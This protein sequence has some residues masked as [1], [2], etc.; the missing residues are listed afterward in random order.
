MF[1][2]IIYLL[3]IY[4]VPSTLL[5]LVGKEINQWWGVKT[6]PGLSAVMTIGHL[7]ARKRGSSLDSRHRVRSPWW[8]D[9]LASKLV[10]CRAHD[11]KLGLLPGWLVWS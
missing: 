1:N 9:P 5:A 10:P 4:Y 2:I 11:L 7:V 3:D 8:D 6:R